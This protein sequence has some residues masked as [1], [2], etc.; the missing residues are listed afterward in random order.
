MKQIKDFGPVYEVWKLP[1]YQLL[2]KGL[3][4]GISY[5]SAFLIDFI[6]GKKN[7]N[8]TLTEGWNRCVK[9]RLNNKEEIM[10]C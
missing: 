10:I 6:I 1:I 9:N 8:Y 4:V 7:Y 3:I 2:S 5:H